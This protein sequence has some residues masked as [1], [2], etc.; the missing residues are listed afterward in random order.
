MLII[1]WNQ[2]ENRGG[3]N[4]KVFEEIWKAIETKAGK[5]RVE[6]TKERR[7]ERGRGKKTREERVEK[8]EKEKSKKRKNNEGEEGSRRMGNLG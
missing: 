8:K 6:K 4:D 3:K 7:K 5:I 2:L 1:I